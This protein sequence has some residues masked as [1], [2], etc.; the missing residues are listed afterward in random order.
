MILSDREK[1]RYSR[2]LLL[3]DIGEARQLKLSQSKVLIVGL[4]GLCSPVA[5][6]LAATGMGKLLLAV[7]DNL[8]IANLQR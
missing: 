7:G 4:G 5:L 6:Y 2:N 3:A 8:D 1:K